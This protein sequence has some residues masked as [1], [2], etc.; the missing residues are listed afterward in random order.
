[1]DFLSQLQSEI[2]QALK[3]KEELKLQTLRLLSAALHNEKIAKGEDL[4]SD[5]IQTIIKKEV[6]KRK[7]AHDIFHSAGREES[8]EKEAQEMVIL[9][10]YLPAEMSE[11]EIEKIVNEEMNNNPEIGVGQIIGAVIKRTSGQASGDVVARL[12]NKKLAK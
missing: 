10:T 4:T 1:M 11:A 7:E 5:E 6:K 2:V 8:A 9:K 3:N 12:V